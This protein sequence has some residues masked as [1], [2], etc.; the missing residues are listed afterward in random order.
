MGDTTRD[1]VS[2]LVSALRQCRALDTAQLEE[3]ATL[4]P[5]FSDPRALAADLF[6]RHW[7]TAFQINRL[8]NGRGHELLVGGSYVLLE[9]LGEG[10]MGTVFKAKNWKLGRTVAVKVIRKE[11]LANPT[12]VGRF[13]REIEVTARLDHP[14]IIRAFDADETEDGLFIVMEYVE[15]IDLG[16]LVQ[17]SGALPLGESCDSIRQ[18]ALALQHAHE[19]GLIHRDI[20]PSNLLRAEQG[21]VIKLLDLG[22]ARLQE[23]ADQALVADRPALTQ[24]GVILG[25]MDFIAPEQARDSSSVDIRADLYSLGCTFHFLLT[26]KPPFPGGTPTEKLLKHTLNP[27]PPLNHLPPRLTAVVHKLMAKKPEDRFQTPAEVAAV[28]EG[29]LTNSGKILLARPADLLPSTEPLIN[30]PPV[31]SAPKGSRAAMKVNGGRRPARSRGKIP[32]SGKRAVPPAAVQEAAAAVV[33]SHVFSRAPTPTSHTTPVSPVRTASP[34]SSRQPRRR[35]R[36]A[37]ALVLLLVGAAL[38]AVLAHP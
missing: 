13:R 31:A 26:S 6:K 8:F 5:R 10:G 28:L 23:Q 1:S 7:L 22:L 12:A 21:H 35:F 25:T 11:L 36:T 29:L 27:V 3:V 37:V 34:A 15:G 24:L 38:C 17:A 2:T 9:R 16:R 30:L 4:A 32:L 20:K 33:P 18:A 14:N 19:Q